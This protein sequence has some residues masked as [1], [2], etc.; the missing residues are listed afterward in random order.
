MKLFEKPFSKVFKQENCSANILVDNVI[1]FLLAMYGAPISE[2]SI[3]NYR[4]LTIAK[5]T[6]LNTPVEFPSLP[7]TAAAAQPHLYHVYYQL[8]TWLGNELNPEQ[9][10]WV[11]NNNLLEPIMTLLPPALGV[12][13]NTFFFVIARKVVAQTVSVEKL[14]CNAP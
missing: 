5:S 6:R 3:G 14:N 11:I 12:L 9:W 4:Y 7:P 13:L 1:R 10:G 8:Q 2:I